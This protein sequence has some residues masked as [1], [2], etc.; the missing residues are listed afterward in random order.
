MSRYETMSSRFPR[1]TN[2]WTLFGIKHSFEVHPTYGE[3]SH[4]PW[5][6][7]YCSLPQVLGP[8]EEVPF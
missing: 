1:N 7:G 8:I 4:N 5:P 6:E 2:H 3:T